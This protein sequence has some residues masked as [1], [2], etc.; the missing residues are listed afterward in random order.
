MKPNYWLLKSEP[1]V[2]SMQDLEKTKTQTTAWDRIRNYQARNF[3]R[4]QIK[5]GDLAF[6]Y[7][8]NAKPSGIA[9]IVKVISDG[10]PDASQFEKGTDYFD[11]AS[12][13]ASPRWYCVDVKYEKEFSQVIPL[14]A[15][16]KEKRLAKMVLLNSSRLSVQPVTADEWAHILGMVE[17]LS[18]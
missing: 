11:S 6:F 8:S 5:I 3:L 18:S 12:T 1:D 10:Y 7:Y 9:G 14:E 17:R 15:L 13:Q 16:K 4:D 2:F